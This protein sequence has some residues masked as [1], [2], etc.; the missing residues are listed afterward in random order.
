MPADDRRA[1]VEALILR[2]GLG[3]R[4]AFS[5][6][7]DAT[8]AKLMGVCLRVCGDRAEAEEA[9]QEAYAK[10]WH[11]ADRYAVNGLSPMTWLIAV[12][13]NTAVDRR[14]RLR[15]AEPLEAAGELRDRA[16][17]PEAQAVAAS[18]AARVTACLDELPEARAAAVRGAYLQGLSYAEL[19]ARH[20][21]PLNTMRT[22]LWR[23]L[24]RLRECLE[25]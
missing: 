20:D 19:A 4:A 8:S 24:I 14:R 25:R 22:W 1:E 16:P 9:L 15:A 23:S 3:D 12:A 6:L 7:Y 21:V 2:C 11:A 17:T 13:R 10:V 5:A 18:E